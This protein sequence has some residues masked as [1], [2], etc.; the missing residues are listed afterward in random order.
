MAGDI[1]L[2]APQGTGLPDSARD[3]RRRRGRR[4]R[5]DESVD[6]FLMLAA[7]HRPFAWMAPAV[8]KY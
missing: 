7:G 4:R 5:V 2:P 3:R 1:A 8:D 6:T